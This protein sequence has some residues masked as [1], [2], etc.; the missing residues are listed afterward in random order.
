[1]LGGGHR[2]V[3]YVVRGWLAVLATL[4]LVLS[5][6]FHPLAASALAQ[7]APG[8]VGAHY[9]AVS[10]YTYDGAVRSAR[11]DTRDVALGVSHDVAESRQGTVATT[12]GP[13]SV[14]LR[15]SV[16]ADSASGGYSSFARAKTALGS[17]GEGNVYDHVVEQ[18]Q[19]GRSGF[20]PEQIHNPANLN[21][22]SAQV[23]QLKANYY[24]SIQPGT[25]G[26]TVRNWL[27]GQSFADQH[28]YG[29]RVTQQILDTLGGAA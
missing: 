15:L 8:T 27:N 26:M 4:V 28:A 14:L 11:A 7:E 23:N 9:V 25:E 20:T 13:F 24:S 1:M 21:P 10:A 3:G 5:W 16:A 18:S 12:Q 22:V 6:V 2:R 17:P 29:M 19:I